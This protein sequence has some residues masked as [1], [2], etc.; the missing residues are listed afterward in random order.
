MTD[1]EPERERKY[2]PLTNEEIAALWPGLTVWN[3]VYE[4]ARRIE[5]AHGIDER[6]TDEKTLQ[7]V[8]TDFC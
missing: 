6:T 4:F 3:A 8:Q 1:L 5:R 2:R 7:R